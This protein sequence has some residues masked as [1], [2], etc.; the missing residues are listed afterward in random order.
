MPT[1]YDIPPA[2]N[3]N[4]PLLPTASAKLEKSNTISQPITKYNS[5]EK[6]PNFPVKKSFNMTPNA[7]IPHRFPSDKYQ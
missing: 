1:V 4:T 3:H 5:V 7:A 2:K 6:T